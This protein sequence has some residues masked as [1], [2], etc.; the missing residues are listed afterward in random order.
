M[1]TISNIFFTTILFAPIT[2]FGLS[3]SAPALI[4]QATVM[5]IDGSQTDLDD[6][7][8][9]GTTE[10]MVYSKPADIQMNG[11]AD[12]SLSIDPHSNRIG[13]MYLSNIKTIAVVKPP[14]TYLYQEKNSITKNSFCEITVDGSPYLIQKNWSITGIDKKT[15]QK[16]TIDFPIIDKIMITGSRQKSEVPEVC[17]PC[18]TCSTPNP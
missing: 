13:P 16:R 14:I 1:K 10:I 11:T 8:I 17:P 5:G 7:R 4:F 12:A 15:N 6:F 3:G 2:L 9:N 18:P